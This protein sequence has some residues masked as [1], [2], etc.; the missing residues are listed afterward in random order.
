MIVDCMNEA[1]NYQRPKEFPFIQTKLTTINSVK[2]LKKIDMFEYEGPEDEM[3]FQVIFAQA[4]NK[5]F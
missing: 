4:M 3:H 5:I 1:L 2:K